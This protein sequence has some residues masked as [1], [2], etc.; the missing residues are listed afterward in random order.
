MTCP[1][2]NHPGREGKGTWGPHLKGQ[3]GTK[4]IRGK[5]RW[6]SK[7]PLDR[8]VPTATS[9]GCPL[10]VLSAQVGRNCSPVVLETASESEERSGDPKAPSSGAADGLAT[11]RL[12]MAR[13]AGT[14]GPE[15]SPDQNTHAGRPGS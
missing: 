2:S 12:G 9:T 6:T 7:K 11:R 10:P 14:N 1:A 4:A 13:P 8:G 3:G 5:L 15:A